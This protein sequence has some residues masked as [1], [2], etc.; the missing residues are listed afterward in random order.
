MNL[1]CS[2]VKK[3]ARTWELLVTIITAGHVEPFGRCYWLPVSR[4]FSFGSTEARGVNWSRSSYSLGGKGRR[5]GY[6]PVTGK[7]PQCV[8]THPC[9]GIARRHDRVSTGASRINKDQAQNKT[10][11]QKH[12]HRTCP[13]EGHAYRTR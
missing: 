4:C 13:W 5:P 9:C 1:E 11:S 7:M 3:E 10:R 2:R 8:V 6:T 12:A